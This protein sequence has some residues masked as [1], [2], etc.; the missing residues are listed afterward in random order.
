M[1]QRYN[2]LGRY[3]NQCLCLCSHAW[4]V[5]VSHGK[6]RVRLLQLNFPDSQT[7]L[8]FSAFLD[9]FMPPLNILRSSQSC[10]LAQGLPL[11]VTVQNYEKFVILQRKLPENLEGILKSA[12]KKFPKSRG[13]LFLVLGLFSPGCASCRALLAFCTP[14]YG[15]KSPYPMKAEGRCLHIPRRCLFYV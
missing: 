4:P 5:E 15:T 12:D 14:L 10:G 11:Q 13:G 3:T 2:I 1:V 7:E 6:I 9:V 8:S